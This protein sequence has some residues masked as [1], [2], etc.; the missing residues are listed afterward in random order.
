MSEPLPPAGHAVPGARR[1]VAANDQP[2]RGARVAFGLALVVA[3]AWTAWSYLT[4]GIVSALVAAAADGGQSLD[5]IRAQIARAGVFG[6]IVYV[7]AVIVEVVVA[8][9]P[10]T[11][12]Y[13]PGGAVFGGGVGGTLSLVGNVIGAMTAAAIARMLGGRVAAWVEGSALNRH[14][15]RVRARSVLVIALL[16]INPFTSCDLVSYAAGLVRV[17]VWKVGAGTLLG[18]APLCYAQAYA[19]E[20][21]LARLPGSGLILLASALAYMLIVVWLIVRAPGRPRP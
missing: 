4:G 15:E 16:R 3:A 11:L 20:A 19:A 7:A 1:R 21:I 8:P 12:L 14:A 13:A 9:L 5:L 18:M 10:G 6:P 2:R 17:P